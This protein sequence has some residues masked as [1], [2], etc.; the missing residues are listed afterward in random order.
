[1]GSYFSA[2]SSFRKHPAESL[3]NLYCTHLC[4]M[5]YR[6]NPLSYDYS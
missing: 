2:R 1:M 6:S 4:L 5:R 3:T